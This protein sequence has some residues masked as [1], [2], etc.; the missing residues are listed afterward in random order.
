M[1]QV[2]PRAGC[3]A[4]SAEFSEEE[5]TRPRLGGA[6]ASFSHFRGT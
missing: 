3:L 1:A 2:W 5:A 4:L 6:M